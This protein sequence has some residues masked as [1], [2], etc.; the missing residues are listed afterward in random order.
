MRLVILLLFVVLSSA[1]AENPPRVLVLAGTVHRQATQ[2]AAKELE[3]RVRF[4]YP[5]EYHI[6]DTGAVLENLDKLLGDKEW[7]L[8][9]FNFGFSDLHY[10]DPSIKSIRAMSKSAGGVR[11]STP[12]RYER[13]LR[14][15][16]EGLLASKTKMVW[17]STTPIESSQHDNLLDPGSEIE[18]NEI[19]SE[20]MKEHDIPII[21]MHTWI[22]ENVENKRDSSPFAYNRI[23]IH[24]PIVAAV[25]EQLSLPASAEV[26]P[27]SQ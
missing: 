11:V 16:V 23:V 21:D 12:E 1:A 24:P 4:E 10:R 18:F 13:N 7:D 14:Q 25:L 15:I 5:K 2:A 3:G 6:G 17:A 26:T 19:A 22:L 8:I 20:I 9:Y 27:K